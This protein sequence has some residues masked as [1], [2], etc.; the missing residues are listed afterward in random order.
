MG[1]V[2]RNSKATGCR[3]KKK[4]EEGAW[5]IYLRGSESSRKV[6]LFIFFFKELSICQGSSKLLVETGG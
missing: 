4:E 6:S 3:M 2:K 1:V 5:F